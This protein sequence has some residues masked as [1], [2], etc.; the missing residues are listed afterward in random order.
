MGNGLNSSPKEIYLVLELA[1]KCF[2]IRKRSIY[3]EV[4]IKR[5]EKMIYTHTIFTL[6]NGI[7][8]FNKE[9]YLYQGLEQEVLPIEI[10]YISL[11]VIRKRVANIIMICFSMT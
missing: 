5:T 1:M 7:N 10:A 6:I 4:L 8:Y 11:G 2:T 3:S 9:R